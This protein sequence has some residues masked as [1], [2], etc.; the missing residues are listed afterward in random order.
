VALFARA[1]AAG[2][3]I[4]FT[5][6]LQNGP[7]LVGGEAFPRNHDGRSGWTIAQIATTI[8]RP[9]LTGSPHIVLL[10]AGT[11]DVYAHENAAAIAD[12]LEALLDRLERAAPQALIVVAQIVPLADPSLQSVVAAYNQELAR[13][14][15]TRRARGEHLILVDQSSDFPTNLLSDGVH[16]TRAGYE[17]MASV[18]FAAIAPYLR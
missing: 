2:K 12:E 5:G 9:A 1:R 15:E 16:P 3:H 7:L 8:P 10:H 17:R 18:W 13:R 4:T 14:I 11:N 6:S